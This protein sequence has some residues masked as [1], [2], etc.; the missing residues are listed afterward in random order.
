[1]GPAQGSEETRNV[2]VIQHGWALFNAEPITLERV[3]RG[4]LEP[5]L[6]LYD[7]EILWDVSR[8]GLPGGTYVGHEGV[9][10]FWRDWFETFDEVEFEVL[11]IEPAGKDKV[12]TLSRQRGRGISS[13]TLVTME[14][15]M[16]WTMRD[17][18]VVRSEL[19]QELDEAREAAGL[20]AKR[21]RTH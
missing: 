5:V 2:A 3:E 17:G 10:Q 19:F 20:G 4:G 6:E 15:A 13:G 8:A 14:S 21:S 16:V 18:K 12:I 1:M 9:R 11:A 7:P